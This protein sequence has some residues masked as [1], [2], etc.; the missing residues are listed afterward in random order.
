MCSGGDVED[1]GLPFVAVAL[2]VFRA[3]MA[4]EAHFVR[5]WSMPPTVG[6]NTHFETALL[7]GAQF[8]FR[9]FK[10]ADRSRGTPADGATDVDRERLIGAV[11]GIREAILARK[12]GLCHSFAEKSLYTLIVEE[13]FGRRPANKASSLGL[14]MGSKAGLGQRPPL[15]IGDKHGDRLLRDHLPGFKEEHVDLLR[16]SSLR[17]RP[18]TKDTKEVYQKREDGSKFTIT[19]SS[20][21][22][23]LLHRYHFRLP[24]FRAVFDS[25]APLQPAK[26]RKSA[27][28]QDS[29]PV[30]LRFDRR[31]LFH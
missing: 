20:K 19:Q 11:P 23:T 10:V 13:L 18:V 2:G 26:G 1:D 17:H 30:N 5:E 25:I 21:S 15:M 16:G 29:L 6:P 7:E 24:R 14:L 28:V 27:L 9:R 22:D 31:V 8:E 3:Q 4:E 12:N